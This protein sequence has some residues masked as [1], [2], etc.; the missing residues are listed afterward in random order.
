[1]FV[2]SISIK[3]TVKLPKDSV[4]IF[5]IFPVALF[6]TLVHAETLKE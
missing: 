4:V 3:P 1:M 5:A 2:V 6:V